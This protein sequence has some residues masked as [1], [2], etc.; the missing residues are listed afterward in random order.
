MIFYSL[1]GAP[2]EISSVICLGFSLSQTG[3][4]PFLSVDST[5]L[6]AL[7]AR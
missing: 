7:A 3:S 2:L 5:V 6:F 1:L 4:L